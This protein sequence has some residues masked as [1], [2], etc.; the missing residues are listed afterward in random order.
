MNSLETDLAFLSR[1][2]FIPPLSMMAD[3]SKLFDRFFYS[4]VNK[5]CLIHITEILFQVSL[6]I[7]TG[8]IN[9]SIETT[10]YSKRQNSDNTKLRIQQSPDRA[11]VR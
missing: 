8:S 9:L 2:Y 1:K 5:S 4:D 6:T 3:S 7:D 11:R 10:I